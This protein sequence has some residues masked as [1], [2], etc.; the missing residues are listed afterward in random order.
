M[1]RWFYILDTNL[2]LCH[3]APSETSTRETTG[4]SCKTCASHPYVL[5]YAPMFLQLLHFLLN[6]NRVKSFS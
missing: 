3:R 2:L 6:T 4:S 5:Q 1:A